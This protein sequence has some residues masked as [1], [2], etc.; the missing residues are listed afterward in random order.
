MRI[1][2]DE[3]L[4]RLNTRLTEL[5]PD[6]VVKRTLH[7]LLVLSQQMLG[8]PKLTGFIGASLL[9]R[10]KKE[11]TAK[12]QPVVHVSRRYNGGWRITCGCVCEA[13]PLEMTATIT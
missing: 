8:P 1:G 5:D 11:Q 9:R 10:D 4:Q 7:R 6:V 13:V 2:L 12:N 3:L